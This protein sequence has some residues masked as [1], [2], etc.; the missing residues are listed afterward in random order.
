MGSAV[1]PDGV[2]MHEHMEEEEEATKPGMGA[3]TVAAATPEGGQKA[4]S[5]ASGS[6]TAAGASAVLQPQKES[7]RTS[8]CALRSRPYRVSQVLPA[9]LFT[10]RDLHAQS[11]RQLASFPDH[12]CFA[13]GWNRAQCSRWSGSSIVCRRPILPIVPAGRAGAPCAPRVVG[14]VGP[15]SAATIR[16]SRQ[17]RAH[18]CLCAALTYA[19][20]LARL[21][22]SAP[23]HTLRTSV[24]PLQLTASSLH[25]PHAMTA[26]SIVSSAIP[27]TRIRSSRPA[28]TVYG[29]EKL[30]KRF[31][32]GRAGRTLYGQQPALVRAEQNCAPSPWGGDF[33]F[34]EVDSINAVHAAIRPTTGDLAGACS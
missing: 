16:P 29:S 23:D 15:L 20:Q 6:R 12:R 26:E 10:V 2:I 1:D 3:V 8:E 21:S 34:S 31:S 24:L 14:G 19:G 32:D 28:A 22:L 27:F 25:M 9:P 4:L 13:R 30:F 17:L 5:V 33:T 18:L 11:L 7:E